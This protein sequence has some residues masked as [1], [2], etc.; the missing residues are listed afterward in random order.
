MKLPLRCISPA[1]VMNSCEISFGMR[2]QVAVVTS[3]HLTG[4]ALMQLFIESE[5]LD[6]AKQLL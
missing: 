5:H 2:N 1:Q 3:D 4:L 6:A